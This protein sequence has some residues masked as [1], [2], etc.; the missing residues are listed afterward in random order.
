MRTYLVTQV[1]DWNGNP[2]KHLVQM[3]VEARSPKHALYKIEREYKM[4]KSMFSVVLQ[5]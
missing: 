5:K 1:I 3:R 2:L 4:P